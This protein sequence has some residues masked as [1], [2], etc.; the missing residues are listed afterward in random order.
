[1]MRK[2]RKIIKRL[3]GDPYSDL[4]PKKPKHMHWKTYDRLIEEAGYYEDL[5]WK[6]AE[7]YLGFLR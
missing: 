6:M 1:M 4:Y 5:S 7:R 3:G 2:S